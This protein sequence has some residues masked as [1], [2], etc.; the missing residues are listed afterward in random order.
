GCRFLILKKIIGTKRCCVY[1]AKK[2]RLRRT[3][4]D[5]KQSSRDT[6]EEELNAGRPL[7]VLKS[8]ALTRPWE[9][10]APIDEDDTDDHRDRS[11]PRT[12]ETNTNTRP[13]DSCT[14][15]QG[16]YQWWILLGGVQS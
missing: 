12:E 11:L 16:S 10:K 8:E 5:R 3:S 4:L 13:N 15:T 1:I 9:W 14:S 2:H 6:I 7:S